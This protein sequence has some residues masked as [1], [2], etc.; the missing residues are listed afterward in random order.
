MKIE[1]RLAA[2]ADP[3]RASWATET[4]VMR[5]LSFFAYEYTHTYILVPLVLGLS[6][7]GLRPENSV[8]S[9]WKDSA[10]VHGFPPLGARHRF[11]DTHGSDIT[12]QVFGVR[13]Q[14]ALVGSAVATT[15]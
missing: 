10:V 2:A 8:F 12:P 6:L 14:F 1:S 15:H 11:A 9:A 13:T 4:R 3:T 5:S 7:L